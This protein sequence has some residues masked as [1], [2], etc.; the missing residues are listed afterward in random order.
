MQF[1]YVYF[2]LSAIAVYN[3]FVTGI[4]CLK[5]L[6]LNEKINYKRK[7]R[8]SNKNLVAQCKSVGLREKQMQYG[9]WCP[10]SVTV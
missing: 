4:F 1:N 6:A 3:K 2:Y 8:Y 7:K 10:L 5:Q 9:Y